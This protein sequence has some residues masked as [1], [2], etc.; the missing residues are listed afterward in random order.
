MD[1]SFILVVFLS[2][3]CGGNNPHAG[4]NCVTN[5]DMYPFVWVVKCISGFL[6][7][8]DYIELK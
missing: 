5:F 4:V 6:M 2:E 8:I 3:T 7:C 1:I